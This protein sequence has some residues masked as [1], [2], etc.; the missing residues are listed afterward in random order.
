MKIE[1]HTGV[2]AF[3]VLRPEWN[4]LLHRS[5]LDII[6]LTWEW[7]STWWSAYQ[8]GDLFLLTVRDDSNALVAIAPW[9][10]ATDTDGIRTLR[11]IG[12]VDVT[13]YLGI[14]VLPDTEAE[15]TQLLTDYIATSAAVDRVDWCNIP[16]ASPLL[17]MFQD[18]LSGHGAEVTVETQDVCPVIELPE[19]FADYVQGLSKK[20]RHELKRKRRKID[21]I[22]DALQWYIVDD[23]YD[24]AAEMDIFLG[25]MRTASTDK[26]EFLSN[27]ANL[28]FF[29]AIVPQLYAKGWAQMSILKIDD[30]PA[31][32]YLNFV[33][34]DEVL[35]YNSGLDASV[36]EG[37]STGIVLLSYL[38]ED[39]IA[40]EYRRFDFLRGD[41][42]YKYRLGGKDTRVMNLVAVLQPQ[43]QETEG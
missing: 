41:E 38:V 35:V 16:E 22:G 28:A 40:K 2:D 11:T 43:P 26:I 17:T 1:C 34:R 12:C 7:Q 24:L 21:G 37:L 20:D 19:T 36:A 9:F 39:A 18:A 27:E 3:D 25:L 4:A 14:I 15:A 5:S 6:F 32:A 42:E 31:A 30:T 13:D 10:I 33:Y 8:P 29:N 23:S